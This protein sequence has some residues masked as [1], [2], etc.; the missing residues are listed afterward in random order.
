M[1]PMSDARFIEQMVERTHD[2]NIPSSK[3]RSIYTILVD[4][5]EMRLFEPISRDLLIVKVCS[6]IVPIEQIR[7]SLGILAIY[8]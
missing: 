5:C 6:E 7:A 1:R 4:L 8:Y 3:M 2:S